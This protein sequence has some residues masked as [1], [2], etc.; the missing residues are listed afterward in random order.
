MLFSN[1]I[2]APQVILIVLIPIGIFF[3]GYFF[4]KKAGDLKRIKE[5]EANQA[6]KKTTT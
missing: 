3:L 1:V 2:G 6:L 5:T 4:G